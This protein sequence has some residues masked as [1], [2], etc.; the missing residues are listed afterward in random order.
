MGLGDRVVGV[1]TFC[2]YP[3]AATKLPKIGTYLKPD[4]EAILALRPDLVLVEKNPL[5]LTAKL[6]SLGLTV[7]EVE[8]QRMETL[9]ASIDS[10]AE[11]AGVSPAALHAKMA[12]DFES[13]RAKVGARRTRVMFVVG[14][15]PGSLTGLMVAG[16]G[17]YVGALLERAGG[18]NVFANAA[19]SYPSV[20][21]EEIIARQPDVILDMGEMAETTGVTEAQK[22]AVEALW[23]RQPVIRARIHAVANDIFVVPG[24]RAPE[25]V[26]EFARL[27][28][29][30]LGL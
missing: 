14:R 4:L 7:R 21:L 1:T 16:R 29:P 18:V 25:A 3:T 12:R 13:V 26:R 28:H 22:K 20:S 17:S 6:Q 10:I 15:N 5:G 11:A 9:P 27:F 8:A 2:H 23:R 30:G 19:S 24:P